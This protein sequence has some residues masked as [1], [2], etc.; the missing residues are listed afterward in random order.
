MLNNYIQSITE[1]NNSINNRII[2]KSHHIYKVIILEFGENIYDYFE[3][4]VTI[5]IRNTK[6]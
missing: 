1:M 2:L 6:I 4:D 5:E 3:T